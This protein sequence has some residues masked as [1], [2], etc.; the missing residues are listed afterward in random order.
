LSDLNNSCGVFVPNEKKT[1]VSYKNERLSNLNFAV[2]EVIDVKG[3]VTGSGNAHWTQRSKT[4]TDTLG[5][6]P[7]LT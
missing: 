1:I 5:H 4:S 7:G 2:K 3:F 6:S